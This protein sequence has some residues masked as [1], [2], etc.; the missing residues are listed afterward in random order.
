M[1]AGDP[2][3]PLHPARPLQMAGRRTILLSYKALFAEDLGIIC[4][5]GISVDITFNR[6]DRCLKRTNK[7]MPQK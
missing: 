7:S 2:L 3:S 1:G 6:T 4:L 5:W